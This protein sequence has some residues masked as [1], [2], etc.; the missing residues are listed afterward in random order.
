[1]DWN[2]VQSVHRGV[3]EVDHG[4]YD[5]EENS[6]FATGCAMM[7]KRDV[8]EKVGLF[9]ERYFLYYEDADLSKRVLNAGYKI[10]YVP[11]AKL[12]HVN[13]ASS[14]S[15]SGLHDYFLTRNQMLFGIQY[16]PV[17][18]KLALFRQSIRFLLHGREFQKR[19]IRD[20]YGGKFGKGTFF[21]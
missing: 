1:M 6:T 3:D 14:G 19:G 8:F 7:I 20:F 17:R 4:Q 12:W 16:A 11:S 9:D 18:A 5:K 10:R 13:A 15:G 21:E 2:H